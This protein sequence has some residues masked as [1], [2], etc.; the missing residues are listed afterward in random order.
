LPRPQ[1]VF[2]D[3]RCVLIRRGIP[4]AP[5]SAY[6]WSCDYEFE[7]PYPPLTPLN[8]NPQHSSWGPP[9]P[10]P[11]SLLDRLQLLE[12]ENAALRARVTA[13]EAK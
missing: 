2:A 6:S 12:A 5:T 9:A 8:P 4:V 11:A 7:P 10:A 1:E 13:L 3:H